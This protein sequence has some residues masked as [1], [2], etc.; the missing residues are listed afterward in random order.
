MPRRI[1]LT[2]LSFLFLIT[3]CGTTPRLK[4][5]KIPVNIILQ[6]AQKAKGLW[7]GKVASGTYWGALGILVLPHKTTD[8]PLTAN[9]W[10]AS[11][12]LNHNNQQ[13]KT[14]SFHAHPSFVLPGPPLNRTTDLLLMH[15][16]HVAAA[17]PSPHLY[18]ISAT[19]KGQKLAV[20]IRF[21][22]PYSKNHFAIGIF[23]SG[24]DAIGRNQFWQPLHVIRFGTKTG[25]EIVQLSLPSSLHHYALVIYN[26]T[27]ANISTFIPL[28]DRLHLT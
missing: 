3:G 5:P 19:T 12:E 8:H 28:S 27:L 7:Y 14:S 15:R 26:T 2:M 10:Q 9:P 22:K 21:V 17:I 4:T 25:K 11:Y 1:L 23:H 6:T 20:T 16:N 13:V 18:T 24:Y